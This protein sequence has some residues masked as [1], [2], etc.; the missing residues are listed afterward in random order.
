MVEVLGMPFDYWVYERNIC[1]H[2]K[3]TSCYMTRD[4]TKKDRETGRE[5]ERERER[6]KG[7][8]TATHLPHSHV[9]DCKSMTP[10]LWVCPTNNNNQQLTNKFQSVQNMSSPMKG[11]PLSYPPIPRSPFKNSTPPPLSELLLFLQHLKV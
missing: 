11:I 1:R 7:R 8:E 6:E 2:I 10:N 4:A 3:S 9:E 5:R